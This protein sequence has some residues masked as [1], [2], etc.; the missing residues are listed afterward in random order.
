MRENNIWKLFRSFTV[1]G[2]FTFGGGYAMLPLIQ[3]E[4]V[5]KHGWITEKDLLDIFAI[6]EA[7]PGVI[8]VNTATFVGYSVAGFWGAAATLGVALPSFAI[9]CVL[10]FF[11]NAFQSSVIVS[12]ALAGIRAGAIM[13]IANA[14]IKLSRQCPKNAFSLVLAVAAFALAAFTGIS[15]I[16]L[17][18]AGGVCGVIFCL[19]NAKRGGESK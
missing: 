15:V 2:A 3:R 12:R 16:Y 6:A 13:L 7:M 1:I 14:V 18:I 11:I 8:A 10:S 19:V 5:E 4:T 9:I 17:L